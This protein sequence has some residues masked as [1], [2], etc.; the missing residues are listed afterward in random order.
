MVVLHLRE[1]AVS[2]LHC[3]RGPLERPGMLTRPRF[4]ARQHL[5]CPFQGARMPLKRLFNRL[6]HER[7]LGLFSRTTR[8][9]QLLL[10]VH[11]G[12]Q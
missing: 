11:Q 2:T 9:A 8:A 5:G 10:P 12:Q 6:E 7:D 4:P 3:R 1:I